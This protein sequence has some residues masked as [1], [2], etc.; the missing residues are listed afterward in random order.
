MY[1]LYRVSLSDA[2]LLATPYLNTT[3]LE[4]WTHMQ[5]SL[6][7]STEARQ[8]KGKWTSLWPSC[9]CLT[10]NSMGFVSSDAFIEWAASSDWATPEST[11]GICEQREAQTANCAGAEVTNNLCRASVKP[12]WASEPAQPL[13]CPA[14]GLHW[15]RGIFRCQS[16][17]N[18]DNLRKNLYIK[19]KTNRIKNLRFQ[20]KSWH[21]GVNIWLLIQY[22]AIR[23]REHLKTWLQFHFGF[24]K[25]L[26]FMS[27]TQ[28]M[29]WSEYSLQ[30]Q[31]C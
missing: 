12:N 10:A 20:Y 17:W 31:H 8:W 6:H 19:Q 4:Q 23:E 15:I 5:V 16:H 13:N 3:I 14:Q 28:V 11:V 24:Q 26:I 7:W 9:C 25:P 30:I 22:T 29:L 18:E 2:A 1:S 21:L 27:I